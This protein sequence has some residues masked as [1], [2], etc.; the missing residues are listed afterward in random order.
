MHDKD[1]LTDSIR[2]ALNKVEEELRNIEPGRGVLK[3]RWVETRGVNPSNILDEKR[4]GKDSDWP[5][6][7]AVKDKGDLPVFVEDRT[8]KGIQPLDR[9]RMLTWRF[10]KAYAK[11]RAKYTE[12]L[13]SEQN[14]LKY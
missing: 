11:G 3:K 6:T 9:V 1:T 13:N 5:K 8:W 14:Q 2:K 10:G 4:L 12:G 7:M